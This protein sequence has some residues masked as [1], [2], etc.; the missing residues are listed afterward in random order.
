[1]HHC[2][3]AKRG[4][5]Q[6]GTVDIRNKDTNQAD[7]WA[8]LLSAT[9]PHAWLFFVAIAINLL[10]TVALAW[11]VSHSHLI[12]SRAVRLACFTCS[13]QTS[14]KDPKF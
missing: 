12:S 14:S 11:P 13:S 1:M 8:S 5:C 9:I 7:T 3:A 2:P 10:A 6:T 4:N